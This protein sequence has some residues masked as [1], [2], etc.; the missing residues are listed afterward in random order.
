MANPVN[1]S[2]TDDLKIHALSKSEIMIGIASIPVIGNLMCC[3][4]YV[5]EAIIG[6]S[7]F[8]PPIQVGCLREAARRWHYGTKKHSYEIAAL[9][10]ARYPNR[11]EEK[12]AN[13][14]RSAVI[15]KNEEVFNLILNSREWSTQT[16]TNLLEYVDSENNAQLILDKDNEFTNED[17]GEVFNFH[18]LTYEES[19]HSLLQ[20]LISKY[21]QMAIDHVGKALIDL[22]K[23]KNTLKP[24]QLLLNHFPDINENDRKK[25]LIEAFKKKNK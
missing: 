8:P 11:P 10:L 9:Y 1:I 17:I 4:K 20:F 2:W 7:F 12:Q 19:K 15:V 14:L 16:L 3:I 18:C 13:A 21:P 24:I 5:K 6:K 25:A 23:N 22:V